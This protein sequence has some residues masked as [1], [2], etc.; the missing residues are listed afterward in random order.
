MVRKGFLALGALVLAAL[1]LAWSPAPTLQEAEAVVEGVYSRLP[2][3]AV[4][5]EGEPA[6]RVFRGEGCPLPPKGSRPVA[7]RVG[8]QLEVVEILA[9]RARN[10]FRRVRAAEVLL[11]AKRFLPDGHLRVYLRV[12]G[13]PRLELREAYTLGA[14]VGNVPRRAYRLTYLDDWERRE[15]GYAG[16]L[17]FYLDLRGVEPRGELTLVFMNESEADCVYAFG[18]PLEGFR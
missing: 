5:W 12:E 3:V 18:V 11:E 13:L 10:E 14:L 8:G 7:V 17:V 1:A 15:G 9:E 2:R 6:L 16:T 4:A